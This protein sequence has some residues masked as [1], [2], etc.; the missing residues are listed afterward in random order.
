MPRTTRWEG[1]GLVIVLGSVWGL[2][3]AGLGLALQ[4]CA[5]LASGSIMTGTAIFFLAGSRLR[6]R[7]AWGPALAVALAMG[8]K[9]F[10]AALLR[11]PI[12][13]GAIGNPMFAIVV[14]GAAIVG[15]FAVFGRAAGRS[16]RGRMLLGAAAGLLSAAVFPAVKL[17][18]GIPACVLPGT[19][20]PLSIAFAP[21]AVATGA[22]AVP[23]AYRFVAGF[24]AWEARRPG[25][26]L[27]IPAAA[28]AV[29]LALIAALRL[30]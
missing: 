16:L 10:D 14:A 27:V 20:L 6:A 1:I 17:A 5:R 19:A 24:E 18:T 4:S 29:S 15:L 2:A 25:L 9:L 12:K 21:I 26:R 22:L 23:L 30:V 28:A 11:L 7:R 3:E 13:S 8:L